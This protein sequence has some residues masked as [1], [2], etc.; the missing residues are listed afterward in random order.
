L[1]TFAQDAWNTDEKSKDTV[2]AEDVIDW[3]WPGKF[4]PFIETSMGLSQLI[5]N[6]FEGQ[7]PEESLVELKL[8]Y[9]QL[10]EYE[11]PI[12]EL[13]ERFIYGSYL[14]DDIISLKNLESGD[15]SARTTRF[16]FG[17]RLGYGYLLKPL[18]LILYN[19]NGLN[20]TQLKTSD[21]RSLTTEDMS[22]LERYEDVY[23][24]GMNTE[25]GIRLKFIKSLSFTTSYEIAVVYPR[26]VFWPWLGSYAI[27]NITMGV[28]SSFTDDIARSSPVAGPIFYFLLKNGIALAYYQ[29]VKNK[30]NW[31]FNSETPMMIETFKIGLSY[32]F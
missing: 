16:G 22:I 10:K 17:N 6:K 20:W 21:Y 14:S 2:P 7:M 1:T 3:A 31:P 18:V 12:W 27:L 26:H 25:G 32:T 24:F 11:K 23:R 9:S 4:Y 28:V 29:G 30:M 13:D 19:Q 5:Q 15:F 8:G